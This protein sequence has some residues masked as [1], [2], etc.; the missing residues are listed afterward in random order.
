VITDPIGKSVFFLLLTKE[1]PKSRVRSAITVGITVAII[2]G[3]AAL[4]GRQLLDAMGIHIAPSG[5]LPD[6]VDWSWRRS[7]F[8]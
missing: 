6:S 1:T 7:A 5:S 2:L 8:S 4:V 3:G